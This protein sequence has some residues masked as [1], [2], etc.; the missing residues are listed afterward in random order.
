MSVQSLLLIG[1]IGYF[2]DAPRANVVY[3]SRGIWSVLI[4]HMLATAGGEG[5]MSRR[6][7]IRRL[8][9]AGVMIAGVAMAFWR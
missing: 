4:V 8:C 7:V 9:G 1:T 6:A 2:Q 3:A 5:G